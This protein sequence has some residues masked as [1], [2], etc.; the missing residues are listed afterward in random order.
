MHDADII[1]LF[2]KRSERAVEE[3]AAKYGGDCLRIAMNV[4]ISREDAE[5]CV[6]DALM[7]V[8]NAVPPE[9]PSDLGAFVR[10]I[11]RNRAL[12]RARYNLAEKRGAVTACLEELS[13]CL[14]DGKSVEDECENR[15]LKGALESFLRGLGALERSV[16]L[17][18][19]WYMESAEEIGRA[20]G[21][22]G[23]AVRA[24]LART[25][26]K[27]RKYLTLRGVEI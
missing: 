7:G 22:S 13:E 4:L 16:F 24:R 21:L 5:E 19:Y 15:E 20:L 12:S 23:P 1:S 10:R 18:R 3:L 9:K 25:R 2:T 26:K 11:A 8:W 27:L 6:Q 14:P 17:R